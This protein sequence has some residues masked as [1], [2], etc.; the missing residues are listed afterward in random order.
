LSRQLAAQTREQCDMDRRQFLFAIS[1][2]AALLGG[3]RA[4]HAE[5]GGPTSTE[6]VGGHYEKQAQ[7]LAAN[8]PLDGDEF[9]DLFSRRLRRLMKAPRHYPKNCR[10]AS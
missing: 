5:C 10:R 4:G 7:L 8:A 1:G 6:F 3:A 9:Y 2:M